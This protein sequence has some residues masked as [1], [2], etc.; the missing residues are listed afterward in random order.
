[1]RARLL[2]GGSPWSDH[3]PGPTRREILSLLVRGALASPLLG[4]DIFGMMQTNQSGGQQSFPSNWQLTDAALLEE[5]VCRAFLF[6][7]NE[8]GSH[9][10]LVRDRALADVGPDSRRVASIAATGY[11]LAA[12][13]IGHQRRY[14]P[15]KGIYER[16]I[17]TLSFL[18]NHAEQVNGFFY[19]FLDIETGRRVNG[20]EVSPIDTT[21][22]LCGVL[23][24]REYSQHREIQQLASTI[25]RRVNWRWMLNGGVTLARCW[26]PENRFAADRWDTYSE[27]M[28]MYLLAI[29]APLYNISP[30]S[31]DAL[32]RPVKELQGYSY[33]G[34]DDPLFVHQYSQAW[35]DFRGRR[36]RYADYFQNSILATDAHRRFCLDLAVQF[37]DYSDD[38]WG[39]TASD[40]SKGYVAWGGPPA[41]GP[42]D[43][44]VVPCASAGSLPF[45]PAPAM[46]V[47][48]TIKNRYGA[49]A[50]TQYGFVDAFN[51]LTNWYDTDVVGIDIGISMV[52]AENART[53]FVWNTFMKNP[54]AK[55]GMDRAGFKPDLASAP[56]HA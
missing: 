19:H 20:C 39:I 37:P 35:F 24:A 54:E 10:G 53:S 12:L 11:G 17:A 7:W 4:S 50:W 26:T 18:L 13:C 33:I 29:A 30:S 45:L 32:A 14:L 42:I 46:R 43:G 48:Q 51:P 2:A 34:G 3:G 55:R 31:W 22:L 44:T 25:Y 40:S 56:K 16:V 28:M 49:N 52:M 21:I 47:L 6:F 8:A 15:S 5:I 23:T 9:S 27:L 41:T 38:L 1:M 36:D